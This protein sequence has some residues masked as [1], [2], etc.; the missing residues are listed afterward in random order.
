MRE[1][2]EREERNEG[3]GSRLRLYILGGILAALILGLFF[4]LFQGP[5][6]EEEERVAKAPAIP[7]PVS[8]PIAPAPPA[9]PSTSPPPEVTTPPAASPSS[10]EAR[11]PS[12]DL[13]FFK[14]LKEKEP[15]AEL[16]PKKKTAA[17]AGKISGKRYTIQIA[18]L[19]N[20]DSAKTLASKFKK[21]GYPS[22]VVSV[23]IPEKGMR[24][25]VRIGHYPTREAAKKAAE[26]LQKKEK[27]DYFIAAEG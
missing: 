8:P 10:P 19:D 16:L 14:T 11:P 27:I 6:M 1:E 22:Y 3:E 21:K 5:T 18:S 12:E 15:S 20:G 26:L 2:N 17:K 24:Y 25:R 7:A 9:A 13:T 4:F 23:E